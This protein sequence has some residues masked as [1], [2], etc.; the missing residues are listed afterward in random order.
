MPVAVVLVTACGAMPFTDPDWAPRVG[1]SVLKLRW[2]R[3][4]GPADKNFFI[5]EMLE[6]HDRFNPVETGAAGFDTDK[7]RVFVG[8]AVG[9]LYCLD[10][11]S[12]KT[13]WRFDLDDAVG[14]KPLYDPDRRRVYFGADDGVL[15]ALHARSGRKLWATETG[16]EIRRVIHMREDTLYLANAD[17]TILAVDPEGGEVIW[18]YRRPPIEGFS[19]SGY[20]DIVFHGK[21]VIGAFADGTVASLDAISGAINWSSDL[22]GEIVTAT[23]EGEVNLLDADATPVLTRGVLVA[24][25]VAGGVYGM[26]ADNGNVRWTRPDIDRVTGLAE[27]NGLAVAARASTGLVAIDPTTGKTEWSSRFGMGILQDP[28]VYDDLLLVSDS[29]AGLFVASSS[30][31]RVLQ[32]LDQK[33]GFFARPSGHGG[34]MMI[35]GNRSTLYAMSIH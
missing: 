17:N 8:V 11:R 15:Y 1:K 30:D 28:V 20:A 25:S 29:E 2:T 21:A 6:E 33:G 19:A 4:L 3:N 35:M 14:S 7:Q 18:R 13:V 22:A 31:G 10:V 23:R 32:R 27:T 34:Y 9:G 24:A 12:G 16:S 5:P 26:S